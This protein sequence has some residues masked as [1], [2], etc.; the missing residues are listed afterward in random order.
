MGCE[1]SQTQTNVLIDNC[2]A[3]VRNLNGKRGHDGAEYRT[4]SPRR[5]LERNQWTH[6]TCDKHVL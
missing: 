6:T 4:R 5:D 1:V 3:P 2:I